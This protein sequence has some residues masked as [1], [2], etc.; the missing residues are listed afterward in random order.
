[1]TGEAIDQLLAP[2]LLLTPVRLPRSGETTFG[3]ATE[4]EHRSVVN[5]MVAAGRPVA[6][7]PMARRH[8]AAAD[9]LG[10]L[11]AASLDAYRERRAV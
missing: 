11:G 2:A 6:L 1:M 4:A 5:A 9:L 8:T 10:D 7:D 3:A